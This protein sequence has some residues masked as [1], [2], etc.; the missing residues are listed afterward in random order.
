[1]VTGLTND[2]EVAIYIRAVNA[3]GAGTSANV[4]ATPTA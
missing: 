1:V 3:I 4:T 2:V